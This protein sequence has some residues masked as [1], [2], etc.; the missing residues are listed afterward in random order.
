MDKKW[1]DTNE[2]RQFCS[3]DNKAQKK[4]RDSNSIQYAVV[5]ENILYKLEDVKSYLE[6]KIVKTA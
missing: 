2:F 4:L 1:I 6:S 5:D 3:L